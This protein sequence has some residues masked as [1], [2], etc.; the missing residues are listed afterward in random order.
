[1]GRA[2]RPINASTEITA[3]G[4]ANFMNSFVR[5]GS[6]NYFDSAGTLQTA[7]TNVL[8]TTYSRHTL[9]R[10]T[11]CRWQHHAVPKH[12]RDQSSRHTGTNTDD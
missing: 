7:G 3:L 2:N 10:Y 1:M 6:A 8:R 9:R 12:Y 11:N 4:S 5:A